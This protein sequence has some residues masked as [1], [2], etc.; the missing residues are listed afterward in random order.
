MVSFRGKKKGQLPKVP[1][2]LSVRKQNNKPWRGQPQRKSEQRDTRARLREMAREK[3]SGNEKASAIAGE[4]LSHKNVMSY[5]KVVGWK[6][7]YHATSKERAG[8]IVLQQRL[9]AGEEGSLGGNIY[10]SESAEEARRRQRAVGDHSKAEVLEVT[11]RLGWVAE[12]E[13]DTV[14]TSQWLK[15]LGCNSAKEYGVD[16]FCIPDE[17]GESGVKNI[18]FAPE[19]NDDLKNRRSSY[20]SEGRTSLCSRFSSRSW[21]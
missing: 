12:V 13:T 14:V 2:R 17:S 5:Q 3:L 7:L 11:V 4:P 19:Y 6:R 9:I 21:Y 20:Y 16:V 10:L 18:R 1:S 8:K 15:R